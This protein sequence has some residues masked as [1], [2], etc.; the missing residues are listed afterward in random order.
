MKTSSMILCVFL[1]LTISF[2]T[3]IEDLSQ[4]FSELKNTKLGK[5]FML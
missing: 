5:F 3:K 2:S 4:S 1:I